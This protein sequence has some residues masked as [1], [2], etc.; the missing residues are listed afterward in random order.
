MQVLKHDIPFYILNVTLQN[1][2]HLKTENELV[3]YRWLVSLFL[4]LGCENQHVAWSL[5]LGAK[6]KVNNSER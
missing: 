1:C 6:G 2:H 4:I 3:E 5:N